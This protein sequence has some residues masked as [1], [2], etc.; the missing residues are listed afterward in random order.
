MEWKGIL[1][2]F[3]VMFLIDGKSLFHNLYMIILAGVI[4]TSTDTKTE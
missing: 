1:I 2:V 3:T 4:N